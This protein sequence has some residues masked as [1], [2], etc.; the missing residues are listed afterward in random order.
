MEA[1]MAGTILCG[2]TDSPEGRDAAQLAD[3]LSARLGLR[4]VLAHVV[5]GIPVGADESLT[6][7]QGRKGGERLLTAITGE[8]RP[9][10][11][12]EQ[13]LA[14]GDRA[15]RLAQFA[16]EESAD[17]IAVGSRSQGLR[18]RS[19]R[20]TLARELETATPVPVLIAPPRTRKPSD[21][22]PAEGPSVRGTAA[23]CG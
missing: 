20:C 18:G 1:V 11:K 2:V 14:H 12:P 17:L 5:D 16:A 15:E 23:G 9:D 8:L 3:A 13:R 22:S 10:Q 4:L 7:L 19:L 21:R 6:A